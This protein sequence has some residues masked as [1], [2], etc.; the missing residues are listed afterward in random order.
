M[1]SLFY[2][3]SVLLVLAISIM[4]VVFAK[5]SLPL[6]QTITLRES[7]VLSAEEQALIRSLPPLKVCAYQQA[8]PLSLHNRQSNQFLGISVDVFRFIAE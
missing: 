3:F 2:N 4:F 7:V 1:R 8:P 5:A 6:E